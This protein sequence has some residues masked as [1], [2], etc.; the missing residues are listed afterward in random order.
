MRPA[1]ALAAAASLAALALPPADAG[2]QMADAGYR[3]SLVRWRAADGNFAGWELAGAARTAEG[4]LVLDAATAQAGADTPGAFHDRNFYNGAGYSVGEVTSPLAPVG[5]GFTRAVP[6]W[7]ALTPPGTWVEVYVRAQV[8]GRLTRFYNL[9]VWAQDGSA[10]ERHSV[11]AQRD[12]DA[13]VAVDTLVLADGTPPAD[14]VQLRVR[15]FSARPAEASPTLTL[16][17]VTA[18]TTPHRPASAS[19][20]DPTRWGKVLEVPTCSQRA[21]PDGGE[22]WCSPTSTSMVVGYWT[23]DTGPCEARVRAAVAGVYDWVFDGHGNWPFNTAY[24]AAA[25]GLEGYVTRLT[26]LAE[27]EAWIAAGVP[28]VMSYSW[29]EGQLPN[30]PV[31]SSE[32]HLGVLVGF[33][34]SGNPVMNDPAGATDG[35]VRR[36]YPRA[37]FEA[38]WLDHSGGTAYIIQPSGHPTP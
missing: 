35:E 20:G 31:S 32:G 23:S 11:D 17:A 12:D 4:A 3:A 28:V 24:A 29:T 38:L 7:N 27:A 21:Y 1:V 22:A 18:S 9:G 8:G 16:A 34:A 25:A 10:V 13:K 6:S 5:F 37:D 19:T 14:A 36:T 15:L 33:D 2:A 26:G 30:A